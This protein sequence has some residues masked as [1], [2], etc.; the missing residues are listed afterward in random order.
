MK[1]TMTN[2]EK[3][4]EESFFLYFGNLIGTVPPANLDKFSFLTHPCKL[5]N[6]IKYSV[7]C[8]HG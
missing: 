3:D 4:Q 1:N 7:L 6:Q 2:L 5:C 8:L